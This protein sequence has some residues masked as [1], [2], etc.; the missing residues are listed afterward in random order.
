METAG[1]LFL[2]DREFD[3]V[4]TKGSSFVGRRYAVPVLAAWMKELKRINGNLR[5][6]V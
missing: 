4:F 6:A 3:S 5:V 2:T 1:F